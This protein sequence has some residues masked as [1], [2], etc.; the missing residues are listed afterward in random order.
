M[1]TIGV[2]FCAGTRK[3]KLWVWQHIWLL[4][5][6]H[7]TF[8]RKKSWVQNRPLWLVS[9]VRTGPPWPFRSSCLTFQAPVRQAHWLRQTN[10]KQRGTQV[11]LLIRI[12]LQLSQNAPEPSFP[13]H[14][15][16]CDL[17]QKE[18]FSDT[19]ILPHQPPPQSKCFPVSSHPS[20]CLSYWITVLT[21]PPCSI[22]QTGTE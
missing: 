6:W 10:F 17:L 1:I 3:S 4:M 11:S 15:A 22:Q 20:T 12:G 16:F 2:K 5:P 21:T 14:T 18:A 7:L 19:C 13:P 9:E 8:W